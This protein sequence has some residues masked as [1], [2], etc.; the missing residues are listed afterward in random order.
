M[1]WIFITYS[2]IQYPGFFLVFMFTFQGMQRADY[3]MLTYILFEVVFLLVG[4]IIFVYIGRLWG[5]S[6]P[7]IGEALGAGIG[8]AIARLFDFWMTFLISLIIFKKMGFSVKTCFRVDFEGKEIKET[9]KY[10]SRLAFGES[11][12]QL[13][14]FIQII[15]TSALIANYSNELGYFNLALTLGQIVQIVTLYSQSL[16]GAYSESTAHN[17]SNLTK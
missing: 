4:Q 17:K 9:M 11:F 15:I 13:G 2:F 14:Y 16:L 12:V 6:N 10:G 7:I 3:F 5:A 8:Y 1:T